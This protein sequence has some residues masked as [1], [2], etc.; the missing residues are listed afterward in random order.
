MPGPP[1]MPARWSASGDRPAPRPGPACRTARPGR[2]SRTGSTPA[3]P[4]CAPAR[5]PVRT[6]PTHRR[7]TRPGP[8][9]RTTREIRSVAVS[10]WREI[11]GSCPPARVHRRAE[12][13]GPVRPAGLARVPGPAWRPATRSP[14]SARRARA[15][16]PTRSSTASTLQ[17]PGLPAD[18]PADPVR[19]RVRVVDL[20]SFALLA[21]GLAAA[22]VRRRPGVQP[23]G[24]AVA[25]WCCRSA[26]CSACGW[27]ST[28]TT[29]A[30]SCTSR[31]S[32]PPRGLIR[33][34]VAAH[35]AAD[36]PRRGPGDRDQRVLPRGSRPDAGGR[37][38]GRRH[39][40]A[41][42]AGPGPDAP[43]GA[44]SRAAPRAHGTCWSTS[45]SWGRRTGST[46]RCARCTTSCTCAAAP[47]SH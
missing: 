21:R 6:P 27:C 32:P 43:R 2:T 15:T 11:P 5:V 37:A 8:T 3:S 47:T 35:R 9:G 46:W 45:A 18:H 22:A 20:A 44:G 26:C 16:R 31:G 1:P 39:R 40:R 24:R 25:G 33:P 28:S 19:R 23:A 7:P 36:L 29:C 4:G 42:R 12:P 13:A 41:H 17:V 14:W 30:R 38:T 10:S 34:G